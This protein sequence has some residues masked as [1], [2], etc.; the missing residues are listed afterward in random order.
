MVDASTGTIWLPFCRDNDDVLVTSSSNDGLTWSKPRE[1]TTDVKRPDWG[2][3]ATGPGVGIQ[4][5]HGEHA[6]RMVIPCDHREKVDGKDT[7][8]SHVFYS[9]D[10]GQT[11][12]LG[13]SADRHTD[14]CQV[15]ELSDGRLLINM[16]NYWGRDG[17]RPQRGGMRAIAHSSD[18]GLTWSDV[19]FDQTLV[20]PVCQASLIAMPNPDKTDAQVLLFSNPADA[21]KRRR[22]T[23]RASFDEGRTWPAKVLIYDGSSAYSCLAPLGDGRA[24]LL[25]ER[26]D[27]GRIVFVTVALDG[28]ND[29]R[30][31]AAA[32][33]Q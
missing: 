25:F 29:L 14:E 12:K 28:E 1:I 24:G 5:R 6:G 2:W 19:D 21:G 10:H 33:S 9:D 16:R 13:G 17:Q 15:V 30:A 32:T 4:L 31:A 3:Y 22:M 11:W 8:F 27:Y 23:V 26:D 18:G 20:E 7:M